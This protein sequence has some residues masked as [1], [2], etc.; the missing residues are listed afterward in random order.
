[1]EPT[2]TPAPRPQADDES[3]FFWDALAEHRLLLQGCAACGRHRFP[4]MP[5]CPW[6]AAP[7]ADVVESP[8]TGEIYSWVTVHRP[9]GNAFAA[10]VP[11]T[12]AAVTLAEGCRV[13]ARVEADAASVHAGLPVTASFVDHDGWTELRFE[14]AGTD[15]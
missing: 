9:L 6:C 10:D 5:S 14:P 3:A 12:I 13:F 15:R 4:P 11:Y 8:G 7:G 2:A 1:M